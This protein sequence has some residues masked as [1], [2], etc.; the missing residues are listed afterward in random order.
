VATDGRRL[1]K[2]EGPAQSVAGHV[3]TSETMTIVPH[4]SMQLIERALTDADAEIEV[5]ARSNDVLIRTPKA[6]IYS[7]PGRRTLPQVAGRVS[8]AYPSRA[9]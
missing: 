7:R 5:A 8:A 2:M 6:T 9:N 1:A 4:R 3:T